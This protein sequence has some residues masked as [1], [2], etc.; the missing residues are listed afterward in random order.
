MTDYVR[1]SCKRMLCR[2][3]HI[4]HAH[5][6]RCHCSEI[7]ILNKFSI[8]FSLFGAFALSKSKQTSSFSGRQLFRVLLTRA[9]TDGRKS[10]KRH[11]NYE[12]HCDECTHSRKSRG[13]GL[14]AE[15]ETNTNRKHRVFCFNA[16]DHCRP[17]HV[18]PHCIP[19]ISSDQLRST[20]GVVSCSES[21]SLRLRMNLFRLQFVLCSFTIPF[22]NHFP[23]HLYSHV[24][25]LFGSDVRPRNIRQTTNDKRTHIETVPLHLC[26][27]FLCTE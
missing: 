5:H 6:C 17:W 14:W 7:V 1:E 12:S 26:F 9:A 11:K 8:V 22:L 24:M 27:L 25:D 4:S 2:A 3:C 23:Q 18:P 16:S 19:K 15:S 13:D 21:H 10:C 20:S